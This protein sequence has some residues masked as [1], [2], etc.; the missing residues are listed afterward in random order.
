[1]NLK[2]CLAGLV[3]VALW[4]GQ[5]GAVRAAE[6]KPRT[7]S[8]NVA[9]FAFL[10]DAAM[11]IERLE[12]AFEAKYDTIDLDLE[13]WS[14]YEQKREDDGLD[15]IR[16]FDLVEIDACRLEAVLSEVLGGLDELPEEWR[17]K[18]EQCVGGARTLL[19][20]PAARHVVPHWVC[21]NFLTFWSSNRALTDARTFADLL[22]VL[23]P[24]AG[25]PLL[26]A[27]GGRT[28]LGEIFADA[29]IDLHGPERAREHLAALATDSAG[30]V[31]LDEPARSAVISLAAELQPDNRANIRHFND[32]SYVLPRR[33]AALP[34]AALLGYSERLYFAERELQLTPGKTP[35][36]LQ[37]DAITVRQFPFGEASRGTPTWVD[38]FVIPKGKLAAKRAAIGAFLAFIQT[39]EAF[40]AFAEP[41]PYLAASN[42]LPAQVS[43][44]EDATLKKMQPVLASYRDALDGSFVVDSEKLLLGMKEAGKRLRDELERN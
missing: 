4:L 17:V 44:Y 29:L 20:T 34:G 6:P 11:A 28:G 38:A 13:L 35:P 43:A 2:M 3:A 41:A 32:H 33:F 5:S 23:D 39:P 21:G 42:L 36:I 26:A 15:Q 9:I 10:P 40:L 16:D 24:V 37:P 8:L 12:E 25:Q 27:M 22:R 18:P 7:T 30:A 31:P 1:M 14:P 19:G